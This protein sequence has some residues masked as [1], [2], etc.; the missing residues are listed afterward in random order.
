MGRQSSAELLPHHVLP[1]AEY[2]LYDPHTSGLIETPLDERGLVDLDALVQTVK[3][4]V[5]PEFDWTSSFNDIHHL[6]WFGGRYKFS[7]GTGVDMHAFRELVN[8]KAYVP[9]VFHN[10]THA[11]TAPPPLPTPEVMN[12]SIDAQR[13]ALSL[14]KTASLAVRL[15][16]KIDI[17]A[18]HLESRL[19]QEFENYNVYIDNAREVPREFSLVAIQEVEARSM[20]DM[21]RANKR[22]GK[23]A[24]D[25]IPVRN[26]MLAA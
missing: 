13:V 22:L 4:T 19:E 10:W 8:R 12:Y 9:R 7:F 17:P 2:R 26:R 18:H 16:R 11:V 1:P 14:A 24:L 25:L 3:S 15:S 20:E 5:V 23:L 6:Q 21:F